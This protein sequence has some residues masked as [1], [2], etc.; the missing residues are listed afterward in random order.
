[1]WKV[2]GG[3]WGVQSGEWKVTSGKCGVVSGKRKEGSETVE[4]RREV[5]Q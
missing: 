1:M 5:I 3:K 2:K 4:S